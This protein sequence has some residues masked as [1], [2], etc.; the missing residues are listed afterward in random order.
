[1]VELVIN[2]REFD[3]RLNEDWELG[4]FLGAKIKRGLLGLIGVGDKARY[5]IDQEVARATVAGRLD[6]RD[7]LERIVHALDERPLAQQQLVGQA[8]ELLFFIFLRS[9]VMSS[10]PRS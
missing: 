1:M 7:I 6:L 2:Q 4:E 3:V 5:Q 9:R 10:T 8:Y